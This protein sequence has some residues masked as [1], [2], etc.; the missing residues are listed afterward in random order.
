M[1]IAA[2]NRRPTV[3]EEQPPV[4]GHSPGPWLVHHGRGHDGRALVFRARC[5]SGE[6]ACG[7][8][9]GEDSQ[10]FHVRV[11]AV[12]REPTLRLKIWLLSRGTVS[13]HHCAN[14]GS[15]L[16]ARSKWTFLTNHGA[17]FLHIAAH[18]NS[19]VR[20]LAQTLGISERTV[21]GALA[22]LREAGYISVA[23]NGNRN[24]YSLDPDLP[25]R[26]DAHR[27][28]TARDLIGLA[29]RRA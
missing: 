3:R 8:R 28:L 1:N 16:I 11:A 27:G 25:L 17:I 14:D 26:R 7:A 23:K 12:H 10:I 15:V 18:P 22:D 13:H 2:G 24:T 4:A 20:E 21:A 29:N 19:T 6:A 9:P 5:L